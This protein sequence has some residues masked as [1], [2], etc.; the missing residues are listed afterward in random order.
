MSHCPNCGTEVDEEMAFCPKCGAALKVEQA[1]A[2]SGSVPRSYRGEKAEKH[3]KRE[4][5]EKTEKYEKR[6]FGFVGPLIG[7]LILILFGLVSYLQVTGL[8]EREVVGA[9]FLIIVWIMIIVGGL[10]AARRH[11]RT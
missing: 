3:E 6:E 8:L 9:L 1:P 11:P 5:T 4:K 7:G 2:G 10:Y